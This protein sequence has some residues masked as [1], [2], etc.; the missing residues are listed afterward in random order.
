[1][2]KKSAVEGDGMKDEKHGVFTFFGGGRQ[3][4][5]AKKSANVLE[6]VVNKAI[7]GKAGVVEEAEAVKMELEMEAKCEILKFKI[8]M[9]V[10]L[11]CDGAGGD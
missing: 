1:M 2:D 3:T 11:L 10:L 6:N 4:E 9:L 8:K 7:M 5:R